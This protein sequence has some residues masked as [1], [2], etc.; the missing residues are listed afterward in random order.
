M[1]AKVIPTIVFEKLINDLIKKRK[2]ALKDFED[3]KKLLNTTP[4]RGDLITSTGG[5]R[6]IRL[7]STSKG[8]SGGFRV[9]YYYDPKNYEVFLIWVFPKADQ[10]NLTTEEKKDLK[11]FV[12]IIK[13]K[14]R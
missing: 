2:V 4:E 9:C 1:H 13:R 12:E 3:L 11:A 5:L 8:K 6:K 10:E 7:K 14:S